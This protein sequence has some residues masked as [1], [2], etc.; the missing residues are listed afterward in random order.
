M[1]ILVTETNAP[2]HLDFTITRFV[3][4]ALGGGLALWRR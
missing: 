4:N 1:L 3:S 2:V